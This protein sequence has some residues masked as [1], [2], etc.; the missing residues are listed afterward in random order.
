[1]CLGS[2]VSGCEFRRASQ[3]DSEHPRAPSLAPKRERPL[4]LDSDRPVF[5][6]SNVVAHPLT[7]T[8]RNRTRPQRGRPMTGENGAVVRPTPALLGP[9][10]PTFSVAWE[11][12]APA[13]VAMST[14]LRLSAMRL[15]RT[16][17]RDH[18]EG[19]NTMDRIIERCAGLD[20]H[21]HPHGDVSDPGPGVEPGAKC[22]Q[23]AV[24]RGHGAPCKANGSTQE[25]AAWV[26][27]G[28]LLD[29]LIRPLQQRLWDRQPE[30]LGS[31]EVD[32]QLELCRLFDRRSAGFA[33]LRIR[34]TYFAARWQPSRMFGP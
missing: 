33:P 8:V 34:S 13:T 15:L 3:V 5:G 2:R 22:P 32:H 7:R 11:P 27:N 12:P 29:H 17:P 1:V 19:G 21:L 28:Q 24:I 18:P 25:L 6:Y 10:S 26:E 4:G 31:L 20:V 23:C 16:T 14:K 9:A 30:G